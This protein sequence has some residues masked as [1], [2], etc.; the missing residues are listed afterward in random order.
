MHLTDIMLK[1]HT[2]E[3]VDDNNTSKENPFGSYTFH[4]PPEIPYKLALT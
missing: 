4:S 1:S 3:W 2:K